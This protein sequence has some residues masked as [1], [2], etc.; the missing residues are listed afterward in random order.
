[1]A[2]TYTSGAINFTG[3]GNGTDFNQLVDGLV[4]VEKKRVT[5]LETWK[6]S[7]Q[8]KNTQFKDLNTQMLSLKTTL[9]KLD[10]VNEFMS[11]SVSS[12][13]TSI[14]TATANSDAQQ[15]AHVIE[16][17]QLASADVQITASGVSSLGD[18]ITNTDTNFTFSYAGKTHTIS[19]IGA[20]ISVATFVNIINTHPESSG[21]IRA[22]T[23]FDGSVYHLQINGLD[24]GADNQ[25]VISNAGDIIF[26]NSDFNETQ[27]AANSQ[28]KVNGFPPG[29]A[30]WI[31]RSSNVVDDVIEG[32]TL[33]F[34]SARPGTEVQ[35]NV[36]TD[37]EA[38]KENIV[39]FV[40]EV[41]AIRARVQA[42][43]K[44]DGTASV[45]MDSDNDEEN[46]KI[47]SILTGNYGVDIISQKLKNITAEMGVGF[48]IY[49]PDTGKGDKYSALSQIGIL[50]DAT[51]GSST[52]GLL[53]I[54]MKELDKALDDDPQ[55]VARLFAA[56]Y[57][58]GSD[59]S[60]LSY[61]SR[62][63]GTTKPGDYEIEVV[64]DG[65]QITSATING[66]EASVSG[67]SITAM[68]GD[69]TGLVIQL[70]DTSAGNAQRYDL[71][72]AG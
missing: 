10:T 3:L 7:W 30:D 66:V 50:T 1:M 4:D 56:D 31:E 52:Y 33:N 8:Q 15:G 19:N 6:S 17:G 44:V 2:E 58:G 62:I 41:N 63:N 12:A 34:K 35:I 51:Q 68:N 55:A 49:D 32:L 20:G 18:P 70:D 40:D 38:I 26:N 42:I 72:Q 65:T 57:E 13:D 59:T 71:S 67:W 54:D 24:Q 11:K 23:I 9:E 36:T 69:A 43:T 28:I 45:S 16:I 22:S 37:K 64:S 21:V 29:A 60:D 61:H 46:E 48:Q 53:K 14:L 39:K 25:L 5:R 27:N 47:G